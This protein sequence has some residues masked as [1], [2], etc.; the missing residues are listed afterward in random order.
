MEMSCI[1]TIIALS[2]ALSALAGYTFLRQR[3]LSAA[4]A[5]AQAS[6]RAANRLL[7]LAAHEQR[8][9]ALRLRGIGGQCSSAN[10]GPV[11]CLAASATQ[12]ES[13][14]D[15]IQLHLDH[16]APRAPVL[17]PTPLLP[18]P[19]LR[20]AVAGVAAA[21]SPGT[22]NWRIVVGAD[23]GCIHADRRALHHIFSGVL[24]D[25]VRNTHEGD[26]IDIVV[27][28]EGGTL[29]V[30]I[31]DEGAGTTVPGE[32]AKDDSRGI[33]LRLAVARRLLEAHRGTLTIQPTPSVGTRTSLV[34][35]L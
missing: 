18:E 26:W 7:G 25:C 6:T 9:I 20:D 28:R 35:P 29:A 23:V 22:R 14:A 3:A 30:V 13:V 10:V 32:P 2:T 15:T 21:L 8:A 24:A 4:L 33:G 11:F 19:I 34:F 1:L 16:M 31:E 27:R 12:I 17:N 5:N